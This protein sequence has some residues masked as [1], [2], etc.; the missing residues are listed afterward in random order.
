ML[1]RIALALIYVDMALCASEA[2]Q[3]QANVASNLVHTLCTVRTWTRCAFVN[4]KLAVCAVPA[5]LTMASVSVQASAY[6]PKVAVVLAL[7]LVSCLY[8]PPK[9]VE[10]HPADFTLFTC[11]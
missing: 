4:F 1:A 9:A 2:I 5:G 11:P 8:D 6:I 10:T 7:M 3:A